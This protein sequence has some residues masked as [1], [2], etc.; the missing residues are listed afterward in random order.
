MDR[1]QEIVPNFIR[2]RLDVL[3]GIQDAALVG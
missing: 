1:E 2:V 3:L